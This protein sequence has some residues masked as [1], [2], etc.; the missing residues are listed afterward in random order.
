[1]CLSLNI[2]SLRDIVQL[3]LLIGMSWRKGV[4]AGITP[5]KPFLIKKGTLPGEL[6]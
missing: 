1:M 3:A 4:P 2:L 6:K 5:E